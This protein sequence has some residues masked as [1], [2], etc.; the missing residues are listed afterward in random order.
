MLG[1]ATRLLG[2]NSCDQCLANAQLHCLLGAPTTT[3]TARRNAILT[4]YPVDFPGLWWTNPPPA[5]A[6]LNSKTTRVDSGG[7][8][9][10]CLAVRRSGVRI[11]SGPPQVLSQ[12]D[13]GLPWGQALC[14]LSRVSRNDRSYVVRPAAL[15]IETRG[16]TR[17]RIS[18]LAS[19]NVP[20][21]TSQS[22]S[23]C[24]AVN[25]GAFG[26]RRWRRFRQ[27]MAPGTVM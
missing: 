7:R 3:L 17:W 15:K 12:S 9:T 1:S 6:G 2:L 13:H 23:C 19:S 16:I 22:G 11:P 18:V 26:R 8:S 20:R 5:M 4:P 10:L 24:I 21:A 25:P 14:R 27:K